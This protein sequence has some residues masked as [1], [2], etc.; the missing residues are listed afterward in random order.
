MSVIVSNLKHGARRLCERLGDDKTAKRPMAKE[1]WVNEGTEWEL[2][3]NCGR[4]Y[5]SDHVS[6]WGKPKHR[7]NATRN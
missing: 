2:L 7:K 6:F 4:E 1:G 5:G 3:T